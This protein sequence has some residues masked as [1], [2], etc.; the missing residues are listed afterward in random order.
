MDPTHYALLRRE[1]LHRWERWIYWNFYSDI[2]SEA[3]LYCHGCEK[4]DDPR[5]RN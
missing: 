2:W 3:E 5:L 4:F 1:I